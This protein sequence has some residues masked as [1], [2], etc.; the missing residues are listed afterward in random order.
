MRQIETYKRKIL[1]VSICSKLK[2]YLYN[3]GFIAKTLFPDKNKI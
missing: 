1:I 2:I 3:Y